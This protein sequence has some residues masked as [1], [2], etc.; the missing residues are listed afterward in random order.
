MRIL[1]FSAEGSRPHLGVLTGDRIAF[2]S[3]DATAES[4][5]LLAL[6]QRGASGLHEFA[7]LS[8]ASTTSFD[9]GAVK[10]LPPL[11]NPGNV[12]GIGLNYKSHQKELGVEEPAEP[13]I[14]AKFINTIIGPGE[15]IQIPEAAPKRVDYEAELAVIIGRKAR[16]VDA[17]DALTYVAGYMAANDVSARDWQTKKPNGQW[18][19]G[20]SFDTFLPLGPALVTGDEVGDP[21]NL[22]ITCRVS[23]EIMQIGRTSEMLFGV[24]A[25][26][27][28]LSRVMTL[29]PGDVILTGTPG[30]VGMVRTPPRYLLPGDVVETSVEHVG[31]LTNPVSGARSGASAV[32]SKSL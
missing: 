11:P 31:T 22:E 4:G 30:G 24:A 23:G 32:A 8:H 29:A 9:V 25:L 20:K 10:V 26:I 13:T 14:F 17:S 2:A 21:G 15:T 5:D 27:A 7:R 16:A 3:G 1:R 12:V 18:V 19:L 28:Y 6:L